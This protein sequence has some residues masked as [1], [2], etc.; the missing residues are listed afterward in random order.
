M[1]PASRVVVPDLMEAPFGY[2][3]EERIAARI[4][5]PGPR[6]W[7]MR[8]LSTFMVT[9]MGS[10]RGC[11]RHTYSFKWNTTKTTLANHDLRVLP[12]TDRDLCDEIDNFAVPDTIA[13]EYYW[14]IQ[15]EAVTSGDVE[16]LTRDFEAL[17]D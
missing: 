9:E 4:A 11:E 12:A 3:Y 6:S 10:Q 13:D 1:L 14:R 16:L 8:L 17:L 2:R 5:R 7:S 15:L